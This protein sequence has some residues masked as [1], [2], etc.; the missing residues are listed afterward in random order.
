[1]A[2]EDPEIAAAD[3]CM[4]CLDSDPPPVRR[5]FKCGCQ[6]ILHEACL[7]AW[8]LERKDVCPICR[9]CECCDQIARNPT[10]QVQ[11]A[12]RRPLPGR[13][14]EEEYNVDPQTRA[15]VGICGICIILALCSLIIFRAIYRF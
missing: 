2:A 8:F 15:C 14:L 1:M 4:I 5:T 9:R 12:R 7:A 10:D 11:H 6:G 13:R 3:P